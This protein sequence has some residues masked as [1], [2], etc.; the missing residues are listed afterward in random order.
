MK[1]LVFLLSLVFAVAIVNAQ[2]KTEI[3][4]TDLQKV[5]STYITKNYAGYTID[6]AFKVDNKGVITYQVDIKNAKG[7]KSSL[8]FDK[9]GKFSKKDE[10]AKPTEAKSAKPTK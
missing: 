10:L 6:K 5:V 9:A 1:K 4:V 3:K 7:V 8:I 2:T